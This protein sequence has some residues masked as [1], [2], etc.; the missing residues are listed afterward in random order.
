MCLSEWPVDVSEGESA[1]LLTDVG[2]HMPLWTVREVYLG[3][4]RYLTQPSHSL[5]KQRGTKHLPNKNKN[6]YQNLEL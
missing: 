2:G 5:K 1:V 6:R 3:Y 4:I